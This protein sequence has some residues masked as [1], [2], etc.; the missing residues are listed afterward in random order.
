MKLEDKSSWTRLE[1]FDKKGFFII[2]NLYNPLD[3]VDEVPKER[4]MLRYSKNL[5]FG[6]KQGEK[7]IIV[8]H[9]EDE[10]QV[11]GS[12]ARYNHPKYKYTHNQVRLKIEKIIGRKLFNTY[13]Y[14]RFYF[15]GQE[16]QPHRDRDSCEISVSLHIGTNLDKEYPFKILALDDCEVYSINLNPGDG[17]IYKG[18]Q[19]VHWRDPMPKASFFRRFKEKEIYFHQIFFHYVL[20]DGIRSHCAGDCKF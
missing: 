6:S 11:S 7:E 17:I 12:V 8:Y 1:G 5:D 20:A 4:G 15:P 13:Y 18:C 9:E 19:C 16:L 3:L 2:Q 10:L 14:D